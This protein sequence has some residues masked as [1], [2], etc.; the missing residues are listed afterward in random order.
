M[1]QISIV[2]HET[3]EA[4]FLDTPNSAKEIGEFLK[5]A[6]SFPENGEGEIHIEIDGTEIDLY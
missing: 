5:A 3:K 2:N 4:A 1:A 6:F